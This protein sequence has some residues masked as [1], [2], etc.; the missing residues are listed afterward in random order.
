MALKSFRQYDEHDVVNL[1]GYHAG[2]TLAAGTVVKISEGV[3]LDN[4][5][6]VETMG[7]IGSTVG[8]TV[9]LRYGTRAKV[10]PI[11]TKTDVALGV[12]LMSVA[13]V[14]ENGELLKFNPRKAAEMGV[15]LKGQAIPVLTKGVVHITL[16]GSGAAGSAVRLSDSIDGGLTTSGDGT[17]VGKTLSAIVGG[18][19]IVQLS[20]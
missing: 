14:D 7:A 15:V 17:V 3:A 2:D 20:F 10:V 18:A 4:K 8:N 9:S 19:A 5:G 13:E 11:T 1:F 6:P 12:T 16:D